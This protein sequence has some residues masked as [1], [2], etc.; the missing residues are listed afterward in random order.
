M[1]PVRASDNDVRLCEIGVSRHACRIQFTSPGQATIQLL[2]SNKVTINDCHVLP[3]P[4]ANEP[5]SI[6]LASQDLIIIQKYRFRFRFAESS[7]TSEQAYSATSPAGYRGGST[8]AKKQKKV[9]MSLVRAAVVNTPNKAR[10]SDAG[11]QGQTMTDVESTSSSAPG[12][13]DPNEAESASRKPSLSELPASETRVGNHSILLYDSPSPLSPQRREEVGKFCSTTLNQGD[14]VPRVAEDDDDDEEEQEFEEQIV[15]IED[16]AD[17]QVD[18][19]ARVR[20]GHENEGSHREEDRGILPN[21]DDDSLSNK[22]RRRSSFLGRAWPFAWSNQATTEQSNQTATSSEQGLEADVGAVMGSQDQGEV[23]MS[24]SDGSD[25][26]HDTGDGTQSFAGDGPRLPRSASSPSKLGSP[27]FA[28]HGRRNISLRTKTL[29]KSS[30]VLAERLEQETDMSPEESNSSMTS[31]SQSSGKTSPVHEQDRLIAEGV[32][33]LSL[34]EERDE[35]DEVDKSLSMAEDV[36][37]LPSEVLQPRAN[38]PVTSKRMSMPAAAKRRSFFG[39]LP[40][41][42]S[43]KEA[44]DVVGN[45]APQ[46]EQAEPKEVSDTDGPASPAITHED[47]KQPARETVR[48][49]L[50]KGPRA[51]I[52]EPVSVEAT[53]VQPPTTRPALPT[54][55]YGML[56]ELMLGRPENAQLLE[57]TR[58]HKRG[59]LILGS[60]MPILET[61]NA[62]QGRLGP[63]IQLAQPQAPD[64]KFLLHIFALPAEEFEDDPA[65]TMIKALFRS[66][67]EA[68]TR[69]HLT[70][71]EQHAVSVQLATPAAHRALLRAAASIARPSADEVAL[72]EAAQIQSPNLAE[73]GVEGA[74]GANPLASPA[75]QASTSPRRKKTR[76]GCRGGRS[77]NGKAFNHNPQLTELAQLYLQ[78][79][80]GLG[81]T[82]DSG[83]DAGEQRARAQSEAENVPPPAGSLASAETGDQQGFPVTRVAAGNKPSS[84]LPSR[85]H[86][87]RHSIA[88]DGGVSQPLSRTTLENRLGPRVSTA[89]ARAFNETE[90]TKES[91]RLSNG[92]S[93]SSSIQTESRPS[94]AIAEAR[95]PRLNPSVEGET[96]VSEVETTSR[97]SK[98]VRGK[99]HRSTQSTPLAVTDKPVEKEAPQ[100]TRKARDNDGAKGQRS[101]RGARATRGD[102]TDQTGVPPIQVANNEPHEQGHRRQTSRGVVPPSSLPKRPPSSRTKAASSPVKPTSQSPSGGALDVRPATRSARTTTSTKVQRASEDDEPRSE[103]SPPVT[104]SRT[105]SG[106]P[107]RQTVRA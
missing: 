94:S 29:L 84:Q 27:S 13:A 61:T 35:E 87:Q 89:E 98:V 67:E 48:Y 23:E 78:S 65:L 15:I 22:V 38:R 102:S 107:I 83:S 66:H 59:S 51:S 11:E 90:D 4:D 25:E 32:E 19:N 14:Q 9:R 70:E 68:L 16:Q 57:E 77:R 31:P 34:V 30:A 106:R 42:R 80:E 18:Q 24:E 33:Q 21:G 55:R 97:P 2:G 53:P 81:Q 60:Q 12:R 17:E 54:P 56:R 103:P 96:E 1:L 50:A 26:G 95:G 88:G 45:H 104:R 85:G 71:E 72:Q 39:L 49:L 86:K 82:T 74:F 28:Y 76:R 3:L 62:L 20:R 63:A 64:V 5:V 36:A 105:R 73:Q 37:P 44:E 92:L 79:T 75:S 43:A 6:S 69:G 7:S 47:L 93:T 58:K 46:S 41:I 10:I 99:T 101:V 40:L 52:S 8:P 91:R 100:L